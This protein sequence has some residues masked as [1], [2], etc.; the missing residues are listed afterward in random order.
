[1]RGSKSKIDLPRKE[2]DFMK[3][4]GLNKSNKST[5]TWVKSLKW[6]VLFDDQQEW[7]RRK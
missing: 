6:Q 7:N 1:M 5:V 2:D 3:R 4:D